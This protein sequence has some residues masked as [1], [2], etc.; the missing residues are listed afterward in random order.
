[1]IGCITDSMDMSL[2]KLKE[3]V[4]TGKLGMLQSMGLQRVGHDLVTELQQTLARN[5]LYTFKCYH[6]PVGKFYMEES[7]SSC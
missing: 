3:I 1:M 5:Y 4:M 7:L 6:K 2:S